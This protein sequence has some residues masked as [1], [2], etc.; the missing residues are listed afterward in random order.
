MQNA[1]NQLNRILSS[2]KDYVFVISDNYEILFEN[3]AAH[4][5]FGENLSGKKCYEV[6]YGNN[7]PCPECL[8]VD[9]LEKGYCQGRFE[10]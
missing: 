8:Y 6:L 1:K 4:D 3:N 5:I 10:T 2:L 9:I 7:Q